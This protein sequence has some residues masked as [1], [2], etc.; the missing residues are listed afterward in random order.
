MGLSPPSSNMKFS[1]NLK[2]FLS[3]VYLYDIEACHY[4]LLKIFGYDVSHLPENNKDI[5]NI[6]IGKMMRDD[7]ELSKKLRTSTESI[8]DFYLEQ[9]ALKKE[10]VIL[11]QYDGILT[12]SKLKIED[13]GM[14]PLHMRKHFD[15]FIISVNRDSYIARTTTNKFYF[16]GIPYLN[17]PLKEFYKDICNLN[18][19]NKKSIFVGLQK[20]KNRFLNSID[21]NLFA[22]FNKEDKCSIIIKSFGEIEISKQAL[23]IMD[24]S[25]IDKERYFLFYLSPFIKS[26]VI[27]FL[28]G[29]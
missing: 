28:G 13:G 11:R 19:M 18:F 6:E 15:V 7:K 4:N 17:E 8:I 25:D 9:N 16:K 12:K 2:L 26:I 20:I 22:I 24:S 14:L 5:R 27:E 10:D 21:N 23:S 1:D 3:D 29:N